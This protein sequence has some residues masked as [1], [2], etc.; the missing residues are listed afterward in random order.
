MF[1]RQNYFSFRNQAFFISKYFPFNENYAMI[2]ETDTHKT[3][4]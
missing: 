2:A 1:I 4:R 3:M